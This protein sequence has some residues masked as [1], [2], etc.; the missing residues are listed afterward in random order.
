MPSAQSG[1]VENFWYS[2]DYGMVH[3]IQFNTETDFPMH[4]IFQ[5]ALEPKMPAR[6]LLMVHSS[7]G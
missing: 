3:F 1:G 4:L 7:I 5:V 2:W 6:S